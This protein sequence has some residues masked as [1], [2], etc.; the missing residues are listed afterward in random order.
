MKLIQQGGCGS[1]DSW[2]YRLRA[3]QL[4]VSMMAEAGL[5]RWGESWE[6]TGVPDPGDVS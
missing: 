2:L 6:T 4:P 5:D 3:F 1:V